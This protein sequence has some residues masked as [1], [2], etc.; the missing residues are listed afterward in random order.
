MAA[1]RIYQLAKEF[2][3]EEK[4]I[5][6]FLTGQG[7][8][9]GNRL[10]AVSDEAYSL[11]KAKYTA[12][13]E[14]EPVPEPEP[15]PEPVVQPAQ[16]ESPET[17]AEQTQ[18]APGKKKKKKNKNPQADMN[19]QVDE[20]AAPVDQ[21]DASSEKFNPAMKAVYREAIEAGNM[22][23]ENYKA[24]GG[25][26]KNKMKKFKPYLSSRIDETDF[27]QLSMYDNVDS[28]PI[29]YYKALNKMVSLA[30]KIIQAYGVTNRETLAE[31]RVNVAPLGE[32]YVYDE[33]FTEEEN[34]RFE[35]Q[36]KFLFTTLGHGVGSV[37][38]NL[39][40]LKKYCERMKMRFEH[41]DLVEYITGGENSLEVKNRVPFNLIVE[42]ISNSLRG[43][44]RRVEFYKSRK[45]FVLTAVEEFIAWREGYKALKTQ[46]ADAAKL[47]KYLEI[48]QK[49]FE[50]LE[51][52]SFK[53]L[54]PS[55]KNAKV[56]PFNE[57]L[58]RLKEY[59]DNMDD[60]DAERNFKYKI[61]GITNVI[62]KPKE[63]IFLHQFADLDPSVDY[64]PPEEIAAAEAETEPATEAEEKPAD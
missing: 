42:A 26:S 34:K 45:E 15:E 30:F 60:P 54:F 23:I 28:S 41:I 31:M 19:F 50:L 61:R 39:Y 24:G 25:T 4:E 43:V 11:L 55:K 2:E 57:A 46:G 33:A 17:P 3:R 49:L 29:R 7:I 51:F 48:E 21:S 36:Q 6:E 53:N 64:R 20:Q 22:F 13:P 1:K 47:E 40:E 37:N 16:E 12:P 62:Y 44:A 9:V 58:N 35:Y 10:S 8:K 38:D 59:R 56:I 27:L 32:T 5:I 63:Y 52:C 18:P 14:P